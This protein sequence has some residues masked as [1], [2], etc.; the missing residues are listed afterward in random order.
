MKRDTR[1]TE[2]VARV[3]FPVK[4]VIHAFPLAN[5]TLFGRS[6]NLVSD[7]EVS[8]FPI[9]NLN[10][11]ESELT[12][13]GAGQPGHT[14]DTVIS[15]VKK[16]EYQKQ[17]NLTLKRAVHQTLSNYLEDTVRYRGFFFNG[18]NVDVEIG[19]GFTADLVDG[20]F[21]LEVKNPHHLINSWFARGF[22]IEEF[23]V[24]TWVDDKTFKKVF[25]A[26]L[27]KLVNEFDF[28]LHQQDE[29]RLN[30]NPVEIYEEFFKSVSRKVV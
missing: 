1:I 17:I 24:D 30:L 8:M 12:K 11:V 13:L 10:E 23:P 19:V 15:Y 22:C 28:G 7:H 27:P 2:R 14:F 3:S 21:I 9:E 6:P 26:V 20:E 4:D 25:M 18:G 16:R 5:A 29:I